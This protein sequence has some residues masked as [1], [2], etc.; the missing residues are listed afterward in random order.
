[1]FLPV[2]GEGI[3]DVITPIFIFDFFVS[4]MGT[5]SMKMNLGY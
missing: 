2:V 1:M 3:P 4:E 5:S